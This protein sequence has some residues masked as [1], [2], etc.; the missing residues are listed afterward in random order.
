[1]ASLATKFSQ[2]PTLLSFFYFPGRSRVGDNIPGFFLDTV[3]KL[4]FF[5]CCLIHM[6]LLQDDGLEVMRLQR[7]GHALHLILTIK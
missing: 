2:K 7:E 4:A 6:P 1:M 3:L 5:L